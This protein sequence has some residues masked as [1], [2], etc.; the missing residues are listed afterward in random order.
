[1]STKSRPLGHPHG[2][3]E[4]AFT[5]EVPVGSTRTP[6]LKSWARSLSLINTLLSDLCLREGTCLRGLGLTV[7]RP[8]FPNLQPTYSLST[9]NVVPKWVSSPRA[10]AGGNPSALDPV[11]QN[12]PGM[13]L[14]I[15]EFSAFHRKLVLLLA[16]LLKRAGC[17]QG[18]THLLLLC[19]A[20]LHF[21][22]IA[23][24]TN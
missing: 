16:V 7:Q 1:M 2:Q 21:A 12:S 10:A 6:F 11:S 15:T 17:L 5:A 8:L 20:L 14:C 9:T 3:S 22:D 13:E 23:S 4:K 18:Q 19:F 24:F